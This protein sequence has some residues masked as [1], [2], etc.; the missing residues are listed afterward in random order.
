MNTLGLQRVA[1]EKMTGD[2]WLFKGA[3]VA[4][5]GGGLNAAF[6]AAS[7]VVCRALG[8][9][10][11]LL[12][13]VG[14]GTA[15]EY[16]GLDVRGKVVFAWWDFDHRGIWPNLIAE[17][18][19]LHGAKATIIASG[20]G[21]I[22]YQAGGG[23]ALG[24]NDGECG[25]QACT[26]TA[27]ISKRDAGALKSALA[28]GPVQATV[29]LNAS[30]LID[31]TGYQAIGEI[32]GYGD[33]NRVIVFTA[34]H[35]AWF[36]SA[37]DDSVAVGMMLAV[38]KAVRDSGYRPYYTWVFAPVTGE[39]YGLA[40]AYADWIQGAYHRVSVSTT[41][42]GVPSPPSTGKCIAQQRERCR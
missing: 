31:A 18:A 30:N 17:E 39:E 41:G 15:P 29:A 19:K 8:R 26:P 24:S 22:W 21:H 3:S 6:K 23:A 12:V 16:E 42:S 4:L 27:T 34:H 38:A 11:Y 40:D 7:L 25:L 20:P 36:R 33:P 28:R 32:R 9:R 13:D 10:P 2:G 5:S 35:D 37:G 14:Y 1:V